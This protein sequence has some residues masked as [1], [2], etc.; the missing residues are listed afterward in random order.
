M[1]WNSR[2][3][4]FRQLGNSLIV[5]VSNILGSGISKGIQ[6]VGLESRL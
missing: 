1:L 3:P 2:S 6:G 4:R 5:Q